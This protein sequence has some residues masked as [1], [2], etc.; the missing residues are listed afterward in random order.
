[1][2][3]ARATMDNPLGTPSAEPHRQA[4]A[5]GPGSGWLSILLLILSLIAGSTDTI[6]F[7]SLN[8]LFTA[9]ITGNLVVLAAHL[10]NGAPTIVSYVLAVPVFAVVLLLTRLFASGLERVGAVTLQALLLLELLLLLGF[11]VCCVNCGQRFDP[12]SGIAITAGVFGI[13]AMAVQTAL[14][15]ISLAKAP[16]TAVMTTNVAYL[17]VALGEVLASRDDAVIASAR[18]RAIHI[19]PVIVGFAIGCAL[20]AA[21][22][23]A[24]GAWSLAIPAGLATLA[25]ATSVMVRK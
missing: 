14:V 9:H 17:M 12:N 19:F 21:G 8:G 2:S 23:S 1:M 11:L 5:A 7:L 13:S 16:S 20:G 18:K 15:Q 25:L 10:I 22:Q 6:G 3:H 4:E 24:F